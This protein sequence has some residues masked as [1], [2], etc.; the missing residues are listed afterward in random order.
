MVCFVQYK[1]SLLLQGNAGDMETTGL[2]QVGGPH[3]GRKFS[4]KDVDRDSHSGGNCA[5]EYHI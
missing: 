2:E 4:T 1:I 3:K 5:S